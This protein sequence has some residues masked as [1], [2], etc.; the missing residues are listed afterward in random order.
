MYDQ[1]YLEFQDLIAEHSE[2]TG[3]EL[4]LLLEVYLAGLLASRLNDTQLIPEPSFAECYLTLHQTGNYSGMKNFADQCLF[5]SSLL[6]DW[7]V[8]RGLTVSYWAGLG[9]SSYHSYAHW[10]GDDRFHQL[11]AW[12][13]PLQRFLASMVNH[14]SGYDIRDLYRPALIN[15]RQPGI[16]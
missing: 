15:T 14:D 13:E 3:F 11:A 6:P 16:F 5:F 4:P 12:F 10:S 9:S 2:R 1:E 7:G 8:R